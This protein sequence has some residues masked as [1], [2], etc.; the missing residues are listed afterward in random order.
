MTLREAVDGALLVMADNEWELM[1]AWF[2]GTIINVYDDTG[3]VVTRWTLHGRG[4]RNPTLNAVRK[5][6]QKTI[7]EG[8]YP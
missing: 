6:M 7:R 5:S 4:G 1:L 3:E 8:S 2:G